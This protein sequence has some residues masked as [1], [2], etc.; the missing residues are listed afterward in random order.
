MKILC[1]IPY[2]NNFIYSF[3]VCVC[4]KFITFFERDFVRLSIGLHILFCSLLFMSVKT[5][6]SNDHRHHHHCAFMIIR[7]L[8]YSY[9]ISKVEI[10]VKNVYTN[11]H[12]QSYTFTHT[13]CTTFI[14]TLW[15]NFVCLIHSLCISISL[16]L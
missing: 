4:V 16:E 8:E 15:P 1:T 5:K 14:L 12:T 9:S 6:C 13:M 10:K 7:Y 11:T 3:C 2:K